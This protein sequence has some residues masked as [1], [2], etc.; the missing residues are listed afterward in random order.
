MLSTAAQVNILTAFH[1]LGYSPRIEGRGLYISKEGVP[2]F[3]ACFWDE[4]R[5][6]REK[7][8]YKVGKF[9][10]KSEPYPL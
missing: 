2:E 5:Y 10:L 3:R 4:V 6:N 7:E 1:K 9:N 8:E